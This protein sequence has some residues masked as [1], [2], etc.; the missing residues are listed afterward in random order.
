MQNLGG[1]STHPFS[2]KSL[3]PSLPRKAVLSYW[4]G[5]ELTDVPA[6]TSLGVRQW[7]KLS[8]YAVPGLT[9]CHQSLPLRWLDISSCN[10]VF[11]AQERDGNIM[12]YML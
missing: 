7:L 12:Y 5:G 3:G 10:Y 9:I 1:D 4:T 6:S 8:S 2:C 11:T